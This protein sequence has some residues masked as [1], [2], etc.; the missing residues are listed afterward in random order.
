MCKCL[1]IVE[2]M[3]MRATRVRLIENDATRSLRDLVGQVEGQVVA[4]AAAL[5]SLMRESVVADCSPA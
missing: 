4:V 5:P 1:G 3:N 2:A